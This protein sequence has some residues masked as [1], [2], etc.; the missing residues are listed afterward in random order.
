MSLIRDFLLPSRYQMRQY[1]R[2][3]VIGCIAGI[4]GLPLL[5][6]FFISVP[7]LISALESI[8]KNLAPW[9]LIGATVVCTGLMLAVALGAIALSVWR[10][11]RW[12]D[13]VFAPLGLKGNL[14]ML[15]GRQYRGLVQGRE[16]DIRF[17]QG[18][19]FDLY[20][21][22]PLP[23]RF[24]VAERAAV[25]PGLAHAF[26]REPLVLDDP[27]LNDLSVFAMDEGWTRLLLAQPEAQ[28]A[29]A[30]LM[31]ASHWAM[32]RQVHLQPGAFLFKLYRNTGMFRYDI[33][34]EEGRQWLD[35]LMTLARVAES[36]PAPQV[37]APASSA[38]QLARS[39]SMGKSV[40]PISIGLIIALLVGI[41]LCGI[42]ITVAILA[43]AK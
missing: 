5:C 38:E 30:R 9:V 2:R 6:L 26:N 27:V 11:A 18:P 32:F 28:T 8:D 42:A 1:A 37:T 25:I 24:N 4:I 29:L 10:R 40:L 22:T 35:D 17:Y 13:A 21:T 16:V 12:L 36:L 33:S 19:T 43:L 31:K 7:F 34:P 23:T 14:Y 20:V 39:G 41:P 3:Q 15:Q